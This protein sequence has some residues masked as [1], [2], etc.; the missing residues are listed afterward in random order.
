MVE[1]IL[2][3]YRF[4]G[5]YAGL[6]RNINFRHA[7]FHFI[8]D[9]NDSG[10]GDFRNGQA[11]GLQFL[12]AEAMSGNVDDVIDAAKDAVVAVG[13]KHRAVGGVV[14]PVAPVLAVRRACCIFCST[15]SR[16]AADRPRWSA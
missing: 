2:S 4:A 11:G 14:R 9:R 13:G 1:M 15:D 6:Q 16:S 12:G 8:D 10:F 5:R 3:V 7:A